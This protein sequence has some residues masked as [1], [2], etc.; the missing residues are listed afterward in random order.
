MLLLRQWL[1]T[2]L[3]RFRWFTFLGAKGL[4]EVKLENA[5]E[6][7]DKGQILVS[8]S[9]SWSPLFWGSRCYRI[10]SKTSTGC[11]RRVGLVVHGSVV[12]MLLG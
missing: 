2:S 7:P 10:N 4:E 3:E 1:T 12:E 11:R 6:N 5:P 8:A 9:E